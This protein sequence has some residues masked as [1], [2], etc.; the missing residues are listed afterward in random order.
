MQFSPPYAAGSLFRRYGVPIITNFVMYEHI[1][2][3]TGLLSAI[4]RV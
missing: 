4:L 2:H 1:F 3:Y